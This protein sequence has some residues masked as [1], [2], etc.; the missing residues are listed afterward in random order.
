MPE[1][2]MVTE[3]EWKQQYLDELRRQREAATAFKRA[4]ADSDIDGFYRA[5]HAVNMVGALTSALR[6]IRG[7]DPSESFRSEVLDLWVQSGDGIRTETTDLVLID[8][9]WVLLPKYRGGPLKLY[10]GETL[11]N[12]SR[13]TYGPS[14]TSDIEW[15]IGFAE[16]NARYAMEAVVIETMLRPMQSFAPRQQRTTDTGNL[17]IWLTGAS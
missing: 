6:A 7:L 17:S 1:F 3:Q 15:A 5:L 12:R 9:L 8:A 11:W 4:V 2:E 13:R 10:R 16:R 14:W